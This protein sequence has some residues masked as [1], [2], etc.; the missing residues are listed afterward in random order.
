MVA[1][2]LLLSAGTTVVSSLADP[3]TAQ[4]LAIESAYIIAEILRIGSGYWLLV[5]PVIGIAGYRFV[6]AADHPDVNP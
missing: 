6:M 1:V 4:G 5:F 3:R 2:A